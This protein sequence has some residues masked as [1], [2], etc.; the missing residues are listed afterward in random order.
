MRN[1]ERVTPKQRGGGQRV[2]LLC[3]I[4]VVEHCRCVC[5]AELS[6]SWNQFCLIQRLFDRPAIEAGKT[7]EFQADSDGVRREPLRA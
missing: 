6:E 5:V 2:Q 1:R 3:P 7:I 4:P